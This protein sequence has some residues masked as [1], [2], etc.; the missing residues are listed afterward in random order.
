MEFSKS[1]S[2]ETPVHEPAV[3][4]RLTDIRQVF[5]NNNGA[6]DGLGVLHDFA[7]NAVE[8]FVNEGLSETLA[9]AHLE[10]ALGGEVGLAKPTNGLA[11]VA[12]QFG[13]GR[14]TVV[15]GVTH[16]DK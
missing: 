5:Q 9:P 1:A 16:C 10:S 15:V 14:R 3:V 7:G 2:V 12:S 6:L 11:L 4:H 8:H 13:R